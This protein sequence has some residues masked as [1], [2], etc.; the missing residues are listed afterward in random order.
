MKNKNWLLL[1]LLALTCFLFLFRLGTPSF[2]DGDE[3]KYAQVVKEILT[4]GDW[5]TL[6]YN[7]EIWFDK[8]PLYFWIAAFFSLFRG[9]SELSVRLVAAIAGI[10]TVFTT[11]KLGKE[12]FGEKVGLGAGFML[13]AALQFIIQSR[14]CVVDTTL[15]LF[16]TLSILCFYLFYQKR[17]TP[18]LWGLYAAM[19]LAVL[20]KGLIGILIPGMAIFL[21]LLI[22]KELDLIPKLLNIVGI[23]MFLIIGTPWYIV[24]WQLH[25]QKF[26]D[27]V[28]GFLFLSRFSSAVDNQPGPWYYFFLVILLGFFPFAYLAPYA[29]VRAFKKWKESA[30]LLNL[31]FIIP[32]FI[33]FSIASTKLPN[34]VLPIYPF[35][36]ILG[37]KLWFDF[38]DSA[39][40]KEFKAGMIFSYCLFVLTIGLL[41]IGFIL[42]GKMQFQKEFLILLPHLQLLGSLILIAGVLHLI[43]LFAKK[44]TWAMGSLVALSVALIFILTNY[45]LPQVESFKASPALGKEIQKLTK[46][47]ESIGAYRLGIRPSVVYYSDRKVVWVDDENSILK[48]PVKYCFIIKSDFDNL[49]INPSKI[50]AKKWD[51]LLIEK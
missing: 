47:D 42:L 33:V 7:Q 40:K 9:I 31:T 3:P 13:A 36:A 24:E 37:S 30:F 32:V 1:I 5:I 16:L 48:S 15:T 23:I 28:L 4:R 41:G 27:L 46:P 20:T 43:F 12:M 2:F 19:G 51:L 26:L 29:L 39:E 17:K 44:Y 22:K 45:T 35:L 8:P 34:Y 25:G 50:V 6:H 49:K 18:Y 10:L 14:I 21:F 38:A 11:Y